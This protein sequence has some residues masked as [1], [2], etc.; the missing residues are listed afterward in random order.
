MSRDFPDWINPW[1]AAEGRRVYAGTVPLD[2]MQRLAGLLNAGGGEAR[3]RVEF[4]LDKERRPVIDLDVTADLPLLCQASLETYLQPVVRHSQLV[5]A[6]S[7]AEI[8][9]LPV[10]CE[11]VLVEEG[12]L[13][14]AGLIEDELLLGLPQVPRRP[15]LET[16][17]W[18]SSGAP[19]LAAAEPPTQRPFAGLG[20]LLDGRRA[21]SKT[22]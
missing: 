9:L 16:V 1:T 10:H 17:E 21:R 7:A 2:R 20:T 4:T 12:R 5:V 11:P 3:F 8:E 18:R 15:D 13:A 14:L 6:A 19:E 22:E